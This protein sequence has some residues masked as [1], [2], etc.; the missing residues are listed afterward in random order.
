MA[1]S[2]SIKE[3]VNQVAIQAATAVFMAFRAT[4][5]GLWPGTPQK[6]QETHKQRDRGLITGKN[7]I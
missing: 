4:G 7:K 6:Q 3:I 2:E 5:T 1:N